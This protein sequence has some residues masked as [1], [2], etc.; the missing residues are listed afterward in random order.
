MRFPL[1][2]AALFVSI[3]AAVAQQ[4]AQAPI[5][6][7][8]LHALEV[9]GP[10]DGGCV[11]LDSFPAWDAKLSPNYVFSDFRCANHIKSPGSSDELMNMTLAALNRFNITAMTSGPPETVDRWKKA[12]G[13]RILPATDFDAKRSSPSPAELREWIKSGRIVALAEIGSQYEGVPVTSPL[14]EPYFALAEEVDVPVGIHMGPGPPGA[15]YLGEDMK[16]YRARLSSLL[17]LEEVLVRHP[18]LRI[19]AM[20]AGWPL[21]DDAIATLYAHPQLYVDIGVIDFFLPRAE[22]YSYLRRLIDAGFENRI[23]FGSD[24][25]IFPQAISVAIE[26][27]QS[28]PFLTEEQKRDILYNNAARFLR[29]SHQ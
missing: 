9:N 23:M 21:G 26:S 28:A 22:F 12:G 1:I 29:L 2:V 24:Q 27:I 15:P 8:H 25:M 5:I 16:E 10:V 7:M 19:W 4:P 20:H 13:A 18:K 17:Q 6:D 14:L 3:P 11:P